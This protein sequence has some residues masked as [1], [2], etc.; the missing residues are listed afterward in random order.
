MG[1]RVKEVLKEFRAFVL[2]GN[3]I[4]LAVAIVIGAAFTMLINSMVKDLFTPI[5]AAIIGKPD[6]SALTFTINGSQFNYGAFLNALIS[7]LVICTV[8]FFFV[9]KPLTHVLRKLNAL[10]EEKPKPPTKE[11]PEC[12]SEIPELARRCPLCTSVLTSDS[13]SG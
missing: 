5:I 6:F 1:G 4:D 3:V 9:V 12:T 11:C 2:R 13:E 10:P 8:M 7:F